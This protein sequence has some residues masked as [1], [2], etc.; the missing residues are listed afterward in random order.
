LLMKGK[1]PEYITMSNGIGKQ[2]HDKYKKDTHKDYVHV[3][4]AKHK[5]PRY[6]DKLMDYKDPS[7]LEAIKEKRIEAAKEL[8]KTKQK[9]KQEDTIMRNSVKRLD[10]NL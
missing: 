2:W 9:L 4:Y 6:Y 5:I 1:I 3:N 8:V 7:R 10:R